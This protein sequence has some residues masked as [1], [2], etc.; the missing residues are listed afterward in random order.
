MPAPFPLE[1]VLK[2]RE[3]AELREER[4][5]S[6]ILAQIAET[7]R[8]IERIDTDLAA[9]FAAR[10]SEV[11]QPLLASH[12]H[13]SY[14]RRALLQQ[15]RKDLDG[16]IS[17]WLHL[18]DRQMSI[19]QAARR[20]REMITDLREQHRSNQQRELARKEQS[21]LDE[22]FLARRGRS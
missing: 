11:Q 13:S 20:D 21:A 16:Q 2:V 1:A 9:T 18:R 15:A 6:Q 4:I 19:Y 8:S 14:S 22:T 12:L 5:L 17:Q 3:N 10:Q 7:R